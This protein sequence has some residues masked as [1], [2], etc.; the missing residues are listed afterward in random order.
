MGTHTISIEMKFLVLLSLALAVS[1]KYYDPEDIK[2]ALGSTQFTDRSGNSVSLDSL[3]GKYIG[4][5][6]SASWCGPC[7]RFT[8]KLAAVYN[9]I[10]GDG[11]FEVIWASRDRSSYE[12]D[13]YFQKMP[14]IRMPYSA[15]NSVYELFYD[16]FDLTYIP[17]LVILDPSFNVINI[18]ARYDV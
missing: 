13:K 1:A 12:S 15:K 14:W 5:Y 10:V 2:S 3:Q 9:K 8:P 18:N 6:F 7:R 4:L 16:V 17:N 11:D